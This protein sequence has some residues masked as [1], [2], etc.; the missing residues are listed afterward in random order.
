M[1]K[2]YAPIENKPHEK[3]K[4]ESIDI[5]VTGPKKNH[6]TLLSIEK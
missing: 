6:I 5:V 3:I 4:V 1:D 2:T